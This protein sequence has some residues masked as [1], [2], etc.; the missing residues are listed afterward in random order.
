[1]STS[2]F[3]QPAYSFFYG[4]ISYRAA[5]YP[6]KHQTTNE[7]GGH[8][9]LGI[10]RQS[11]QQQNLAKFNAILCKS[12]WVRFDL[13]GQTIYINY[14]DFPNYFSI[15]L[16]LFNANLWL[17][18]RLPDLRSPNPEKDTALRCQYQYRYQCRCRCQCRLL[19]Y[20]EGTI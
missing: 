4:Q 11:G 14:L 19:Q 13:W 3:G 6:A 7:P 10:E 2:K 15:F 5:A 9:L 1:M 8:Y 18:K 20:T 12:I 16:H 17:E